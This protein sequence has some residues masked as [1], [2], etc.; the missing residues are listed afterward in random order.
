MIEFKKSQIDQRVLTSSNYYIRIA[1][2]PD[3]AAA[4]VPP[5]GLDHLPIGRL[6]LVDPIQYPYI[7]NWAT[8]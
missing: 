1:I 4:V 8:K 5:A 6:L 2:S 7:P 3:S